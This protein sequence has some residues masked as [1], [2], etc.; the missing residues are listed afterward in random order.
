MFA[1][2]VMRLIVLGGFV[3]VVWLAYAA[4]SRRKR[5]AP[6]VPFGGGSAPDDPP[7]NPRQS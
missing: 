2:W 4:G 6:W 1:E 3:A 5:P 7:S